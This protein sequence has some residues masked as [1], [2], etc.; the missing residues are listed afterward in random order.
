[1]QGRET[2]NDASGRRAQ[3]WRPFGA[4]ESRGVRTGYHIG[5]VGVSALGL[6][7]AALLLTSWWLLFAIAG[8]WT[9]MGYALFQL[10]RAA[11]GQDTRWRDVI[12]IRFF[13]VVVTG[14]VPYCM[15][16]A[17]SGICASANPIWSVQGAH[18]HGFLAARSGRGRAN[19]PGSRP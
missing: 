2:G 7:A 17:G 12:A 15:A 8:S 6:V 13:F 16:S 10:A 18:D 1:M 19:W 11:R 3:I 4:Q 5:I 14:S 9:A